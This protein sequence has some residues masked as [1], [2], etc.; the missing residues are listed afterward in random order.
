[1]I[2]NIIWHK[3]LHKKKFL[4]KIDLFKM[5][6]DINN[7]DTVNTYFQPDDTYFNKKKINN[8]ILKVIETNLGN[9]RKSVNV[10]NNFYSNIFYK[11]LI[12]ANIILNYLKKNSE[13]RILEIGAGLGVLQVIL[14]NVI[15]KTRVTLIDF[16]KNLNVQKYYLLNEYKKNPK[17]EFNYHT[18]E[19]LNLKNL[20]KVNSEKFDLVINTDSMQEMSLRQINIYLNYIFENI[21]DEGIFYFQNHYHHEK[22]TY[23]FDQVYNF[24]KKFEVIYEL[25][26]EKY[27]CGQN[28]NQIS[29]IL[30]KNK[31]S[32]KY[33]PSSNLL[34]NSKQKKLIKYLN[35][36][37]KNKNNKKK[38]YES[39][40]NKLNSNRRSLFYSNYWLIKFFGLSIAYC[41]SSFLNKKFISNILIRTKCNRSKL[42]IL[43]IIHSYDNRFKLDFFKKHFEFKNLDFYDQIIYA[44][45]FSLNDVECKKILS[46]KSHYNNKI[47]E[48]VLNNLLEQLSE[49]SIHNL[50]NLVDSKQLIYDYDFF[51]LLHKLK[52]K[53]F[54]FSKN[55]LI[56]KVLKTKTINTILIK[57]LIINNFK[58]NKIE[59]FLKKIDYY[60]KNFICKI[61]LLFY[62]N[63]VTIKNNLTKRILS[64]SNYRELLFIF[65]IFL[66]L[67]QKSGN[68]II[69]KD[70]LDRMKKF[71][72]IFTSQD[73]EI[74]N[75][76]V[77]KK[78]H[79]NFEII[80]L[81]CDDSQ[82][83]FF[84][85]PNWK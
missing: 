76:L 74:F 18:V 54:N 32:K 12:T 3:T 73:I 6:G 41:D 45:I 42:R 68:L 16:K 70:I 56:K 69:L 20:K 40:K 47:I 43:K 48:F 62:P 37:E 78:G 7:I 30:K 17:K 2:T 29:L 83:Y 80:K 52:L 65:E 10:N 23:K 24:K 71:K 15:K 64:S 44:K 59:K 22:S 60:E 50:L 8:S 1:M 51:Y 13:I 31:N 66:E 34:K 75:Y 46:K 11:D 4:K 77:K 36:L 9:P 84:D 81:V 39:L 79:L 28:E 67:N 26:K 27:F 25:F 14:N 49:K 63:S 53:K 85:G 72:S 19:G 57:Y 38:I 82:K 58:L 33:I 21:K 5:P 35:L 55:F 61:V